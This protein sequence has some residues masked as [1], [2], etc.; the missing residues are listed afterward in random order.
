MGGSAD[1]D[2]IAARVDAILTRRAPDGGFFYSDLEVRDF[3]V[4]CIFELR[5]PVEG[6]VK[7][8]YTDFVED[9]EVPPDCETEEDFMA[10]IRAY[11]AQNPL[12]PQILAEFSEFGR[13]EFFRAKE[14]FKDPAE[15]ARLKQIMQSTGRK[16]EL[17]APE[18]KKPVVP[19]AP[20]LVRGLQKK[21]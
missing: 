20:K 4:V 21:T 14:G 10:A 3:T 16:Q 6:R 8:A 19:D 15:L 11:F 12:N 18:V 9:L 5:I 7:D 13:S 17:R 2:R 1:H